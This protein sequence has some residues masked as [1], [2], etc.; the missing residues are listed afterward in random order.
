AFNEGTGRVVFN[1]SG[2][3]FCS[4]EEFN[5]LEVNKPSELLYN[6]PSSSITCQV[7]DWT[8]G[9]IEIAAGTFTALDLAD[10]GLYGS[11]SVKAGGTINLH[12]AASGWI[13]L[14]GELN[15]DGGG[16]INIY[17]GSM[18]S[19]W[20]YDGNAKINMN[21][22]VLD[23][24]DWGIYIYY[25]PTYS[26]TQNIT[27][28]TIRTSMGFECDRSNFTPL[29]GTLEFYGSTNTFLDM[30]SGSHLRNVIINKSSK[31]G[32]ESYTGEPV[33]DQRSGKLISDGTRA[34]N[35]SLYS[36]IEILG[37]LTINSGSF[38]TLPNQVSV[39]GNVAINN[40]GQ[41]LVDAGAGIAM[42]A[43]KSVTVNNGGLLEFNGTA[44]TQSK[45]TRKSS[46]Y[47][48]LNIESGGKI[49]AEHT[50]FEYM[51]TN[52][53]NIKPGAIVDIGKSF[54]N[55]IFRSGQS[56]GRL[57]TIDNSQTF[58]VN[59]AMFPY[60]SWG[61]NFNVYKSVDS[62][63]VT[64][65]GH[66][67]DFSGSEFEW[68]WFKRIHWG[69]EVAGNVELQGVDVV[70]GQDICFDATNTLT[71]AGGGNTFVVQDGGNVNLIAGH[72]IRMLEGTSVHS[73]AYLHAYISNVYCTL[74]P[75]MLAAEEDADAYIE[76]VSEK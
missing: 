30:V 52:G 60:N 46:G 55:C 17:G 6:Y 66:S 36:D 49:G 62:G 32:N 70:N 40:G 57:L 26:F 68:D 41:L 38:N 71:I 59:Y 48:A 44:G 25:S 63:V 28:G 15:F 37:N 51:N 12:Q 33:Y 61:G 42:A 56:G 23:F 18:P 72:N 53:V 10:N 19:W 20:S 45:I 73:G 47:Y 8:S 74:P 2:E 1:G 22:G 3:Q 4:T 76:T 13:D 54:N 75:A 65:G 50:I 27:G 67:G 5:I 64:F 34:N 7:Y 69:G 43:S 24:K 16:N 35:I 29:G 21:G 58:S 14:N 31:E 39:S 11:Y 9:G